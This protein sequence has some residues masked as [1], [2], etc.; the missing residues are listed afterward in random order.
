MKITLKNYNF[1]Q[2]QVPLAFFSISILA[3][4]SERMESLGVPT[5]YDTKL[6]IK[7]DR[8]VKHQASWNK[9]QC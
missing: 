9:G 2:L 7:Q 3:I 4:C 6:G 5:A 1:L 8:T